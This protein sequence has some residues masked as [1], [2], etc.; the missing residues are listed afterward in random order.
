MLKTPDQ[1]TPLI[2]AVDH[3]VPVTL[4]FRGDELLVHESD[5]SPADESTCAVIGFRAPDLH[6]VG[7]WNE[8][9]FR[10]T[11]IER[12]TAAP[13]GH[14][15][16]KLRA[17]F[18]A[19]DEQLLAIAGRAYQIAE[20]AR[21]H[22][23]CGACASVMAKADGERCM[24]CPSCGMTAYPRIS[25][26]MMVLIRKGDAMLLARNVASPT[27]RFSAL[28]GF[29]EAGESI[30]EAVHREVMEEVGLQ[31]HKLRYFGS[32]S[33]SFPHS[34]MIA[35]TAEYLA[36]EISV[37]P[38]EIA[39]AAWYGPSDALP[40]YASEISIAG[41]LINAHLATVRHSSSF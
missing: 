13:P 21:T 7:I 9:Y 14:Q 30:E 11:W 18:G 41:A 28:A 26:A 36:G 20:W 23:Y 8:K 3:L 19:L 22:R 32:Q 35:F 1:F 5:L 17:L 27:G 2:K 24:R 29:L 12:D 6:S 37:D 16:K 31:V 4:V 34:L 40:E 39:E 15:F 25:P 38:S 33:W 10:T